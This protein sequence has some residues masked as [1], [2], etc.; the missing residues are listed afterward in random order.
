MPIIEILVAA[1]ANVHAR[2]HM[3]LTIAHHAALA[4]RD[5]YLA[6]VVAAGADVRV[7]DSLGRTPLYCGAGSAMAGVEVLMFHACNSLNAADIEQLSAALASHE[8]KLLL[9]SIQVSDDDEARNMIVAL[10]ATQPT[11]QFLAADG[12]DD[13]RR[14]AVTG[15]PYVLTAALLRS[16]AP[17][18]QIIGLEHTRVPT[19]AD[20]QAMQPLDP[21]KLRRTQFYLAN[22]EFSDLTTHMGY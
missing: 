15:V 14:D 11:I 17:T 3:G 10:C 6:V 8:V 4:G 16:A 20:L 1:G 2:D 13:S 18:R 22:G 12:L 19:P 5:D 9:L 7:V 21:G